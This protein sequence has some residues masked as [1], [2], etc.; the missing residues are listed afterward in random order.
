[1]LAAVMKKIGIGSALCLLLVAGVA[2]A[3][4]L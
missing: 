4:Q 2:T 1:M 3:A